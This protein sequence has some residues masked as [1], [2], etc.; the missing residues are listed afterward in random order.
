MSTRPSELD[1]SGGDEGAGGAA[2]APSSVR[3]RAAEAV[4]A[5]PPLALPPAAAADE[6]WWVAAACAPG[7]LLEDAAL[8]PRWAV[9]Q[10]IVESFLF[11]LLAAACCAWALAAPAAWPVL[12]LPLPLHR[13]PVALAIECVRCPTFAAARV[14]QMTSS[15]VS[16]GAR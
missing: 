2:A 9:H 3:R 16:Q 12:F 5:V 10:A 11:A 1:V 6:A 4:P 14:P 13:A 8:A 7:A 15:F